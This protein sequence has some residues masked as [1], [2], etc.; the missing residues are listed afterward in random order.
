[1]C[2]FERVLGFL[3]LGKH[4][5]FMLC[6][7]FYFQLQTRKRSVRVGISQPAFGNR[8]CIYLCHY[9]SSDLACGNAILRRLPDRLQETSA[10]CIYTYLRIGRV[11]F[12]AC[13][14]EDIVWVGCLATHVD[15]YVMYRHQR[16]RLTKGFFQVSE[17][18]LTLILSFT[19]TGFRI[20]S[21]SRLP[22]ASPCSAAPPSYCKFPV[23]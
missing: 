2:S 13:G 9:L 3:F 5:N 11:P 16:S 20:F 18:Y 1:M 15:R 14:A 8:N 19:T 21:Y 6:L 12:L 10:V 17:L 23:V 22:L 7:S 4:V